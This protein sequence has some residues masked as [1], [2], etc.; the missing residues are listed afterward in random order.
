MIK[1]ETICTP[2]LS[3]GCVAGVMRKWLIKKIREQGFTLNEKTITEEDLMNAEE[4][5]LS[6]SIYNIRWVSSLENK[7]YS[8]LHTGKIAGLLAKN[9]PKEFC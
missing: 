2:L 3:E 7:K 6:N 8:G 9:Y 1:D 4:V 5:F